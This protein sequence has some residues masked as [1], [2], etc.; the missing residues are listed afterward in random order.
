MVP[1][2]PNSGKRSSCRPPEAKGRRRIE[3]KEL[4]ILTGISGA[5]KASAL[6]TFEDLGYH[7][8]DNLPL[9]LLPEFAV[10]VGKSR[11]IERAAIVVD[12]REGQTLDRLAGNSQKCQADAAYAGCLSRCAGCSAGAALL[13]DA[14]AAS[15]GP[16]GDCV[17]LDCG[18]AAAARPHPQ[19]RGY[20]DRHI[21]LQ[22]ARVARAYP[23]ALWA[24][25]QS[26]SDCWSPA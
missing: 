9:E 5:G 14:A 19:R 6:K 26:H 24:R 18:R 8:V 20:A 7:A 11:D 2:Q 13:R 10:L 21:E 25:R 22:C 16:F 4:V 1:L 3:P 23:G 12:V 17:A 15:A